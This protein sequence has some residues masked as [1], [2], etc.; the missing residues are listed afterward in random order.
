LLYKVRLSSVAISSSALTLS[1]FPMD[2]WIKQVFFSICKS[3]KMMK[4]KNE[5]LEVKSLR[6]S[7]VKI[8]VII[9]FNCINQRG[10]HCLQRKLISVL[11]IESKTKYQHLTILL[12]TDLSRMNKN[13]C[14]RY[15][16]WW[17][18]FFLFIFNTNLYFTLSPFRECP[19]SFLCCNLKLL[20][21]LLIILLSY[22]FVK[23]II[24]NTKPLSKED[25]SCQSI[26]HSIAK[27]PSIKFLLKID[28]TRS[29]LVAPHYH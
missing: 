19:H 8:W 20:L 25:S 1:Y 6:G 9:K 15:K 22:K 7:K 16:I 28:F 3:I 24:H 13:V 17:N 10:I 11:L 23:K 21:C 14:V 26:L 18:N 12:S 2:P 29:C 5:K 27:Y 4:R